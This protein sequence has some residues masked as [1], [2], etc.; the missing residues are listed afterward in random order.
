MDL[1]FKKI[2]HKSFPSSGRK[3]MA[4]LWED[5]WDDHS[6]KTTFS[7]VVCDE[8][9]EQHTIGKL[10]LGIAGME[11]GWSSEKLNDTFEDLDESHFS[12]GQDEE[13]YK[14]IRELLSPSLGNYILEK[15]NDV[16]YSKKCF[17]LALNE[18]VFKTSLLRS[19]S[20]SIIHG[21][22]S[23]ILNGETPLTEFNFFYRK[24]QTEESAQ[25]DLSFE[26][27]PGSLPS[28][29]IHVLIGR[30]GVGKTT[31]L[32]NIVKAI[33]DEP[34]EDS[35]VGLLHCE[36]DFEIKT[37]LPKDYF[38]SISSVSFSA[39]DPFIPPQNRP[40]RSL[41]TCYFYIGLK[42]NND[43]NIN[44]LKSTEQLRCDFIDSLEVCFGL[45]SKKRRWLRAI[46][47]LESDN[48]FADMNLTRL[49]Y[50]ERFSE[51]E[52]SISNLVERMSS[53]HMIVLLTITSLIETIE[54]KTLVLID[55][56]ESHLH[57]PLLSAFTRALSDLLID[58]NAVAIIATHSPVVLQE[59]P[60]NCVWKL[61][62]TRN[63][64]KSFRPE[65]ET[66]GENVG[67][68]TREIFGLEVIK[69]GFH[70]LLAKSVK[71]GST[72]DEIM[73]NYEAQLGFEGQAILR[74]LIANREADNESY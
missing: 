18:P 21:Q 72:F 59:V 60:K 39:F 62:R 7:L 6:F 5:N 57:P 24:E 27:T 41:G 19:V 14:N 54:E 8:N 40:D 45:D 25:V 73:D 42:V 49:G 46:K 29:N 9:R 26:V 37:N 71:S 51:V 67:I 63:E 48:N 34:S 17:D 70:A 28:S 55:E 61:E 66:F 36:Q 15:L 43:E 47:T 16:A 44:E 1:T 50:L 65:N 58:R 10:K 68:L 74:A 2:G 31:L 53:G 35:D 13:Y 4:Y 22:Y 64:G 32:N 30:N 23:R 20:V 69:S 33:I 12:L 11:A 52:K 3:L 38:S 56:P